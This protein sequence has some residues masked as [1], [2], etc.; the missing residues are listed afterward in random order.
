MKAVILAGGLGKR[1]RPL[2]NHVPK[3]MLPL[4]GRPIID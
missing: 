2:T 3:A 1:L 4:H